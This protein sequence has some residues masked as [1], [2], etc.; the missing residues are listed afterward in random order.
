MITLKQYIENYL[1]IK[2]KKNEI[3]NLKL[4]SVQQRMYDKFAECYN[5]DKPFIAIVLKARQMGISTFTEALM[6]ALT[7]THHNTT[8]MI[9]AHDS[10]S[11]RAIYNMSL[12][13]YENLPKEIKPM[14][15]Y[16]NAKE[17][18]FKNPSRDETE[19]SVNPGLNSAI[20]VQTAGKDSI[21]RGQTINYMHLSEVAFWDNAE[22][23]ITGLLPSMPA[24]GKQFLVIESTANGYNYF[25][26]IWDKAVKGE[27][28][29]IPFFF[30]WFEMKEYRLP[31]S[32]FT[33]NDEEKRLKDLYDLDLDQLEWRRWAIHN[34]CNDNIDKFKQEFPAC[35]EE[36]FLLSGRPVF[37]TEKIL[38]RIASCPDPLTIGQFINGKFVNDV[39]GPVKIF[40]N[41]LV[42][43]KYVI[44]GDTAGEGSDYFTAYI[45]DNKNGK[46][47][48]SY[49]YQVDEPMYVKNIYDIGKYYNWAFLG[50]ESNFSSY[51]NIKLQEMNY[52][53]LYVRE[54]LDSYTGKF[55]KKFGFNTNSATRPIVVSTLVDIVNNN[56]DLICDK[57]L[58]KEMLS[59]VRNDVGRAE[60]AQGQHDDQVMAC[61][62]CYVV[63]D[64]APTDPI[65]FEDIEDDD[66][67][68]VY[69]IYGD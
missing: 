44:G 40:E 29:Y 43:H 33:L 46:Q 31:Y 51:P 55:I 12:L 21:G 16:S 58:L 5:N 39:N 41:P 35:P 24:D 45:I 56:I 19:I 36:A 18:V 26:S 17:L 38:N 48:A 53:N 60:A 42:G 68:N 30:A 27:N 49:R 28:N 2:N 34:I 4:N 63:R 15:K 1:K 9:V 50:I 13:M 65:I 69:N 11:T 54:T 66:D 62:I 6:F 25:Q 23:L 3:V 57:D 32:G 14:I 22:E 20:R 52:P 67:F 59:F 8:S 47:V 61:G 10:E 64:Q 7:C 37:N